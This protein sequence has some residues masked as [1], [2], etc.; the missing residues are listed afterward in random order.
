MNWDAIGAIAETLGAVGVIASLVYLARQMS[1]NARAT[2]TASHQQID[3]AM[4]SM[5]LAAVS[6]PGLDGVVSRG[7]ANFGQLSKEDAF[8][9]NF[10]CFAVVRR[11]DA[12]YYQYRSGMLEEARWQISLRDLRAFLSNPGLVQWWKTM[13]PNLSPEFAALV[14]EILAEEPDRGE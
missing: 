7:M 13:P 14:E 1:Q 5:F 10:W 2:Q 12:A 8:R 6:V 9:F 3:E 4:S 11:F